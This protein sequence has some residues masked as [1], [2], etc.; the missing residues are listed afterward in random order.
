LKEK[1]AKQRH[2]TNLQIAML[3]NIKKI[4]ESLPKKIKCHIGEGFLKAYNQ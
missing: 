4:P 3:K 2:L 1:R